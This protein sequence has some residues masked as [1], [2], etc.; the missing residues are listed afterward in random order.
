MKKLLLIAVL[1]LG[2]VACDKNELG[3]DMD[4]SSINVPTEKMIDAKFD[5]AFDFITSLNGSDIMIERKVKSTISTA[6]A[7]DH[8]DNWLQINFFNVGTQDF[9]FL[10][11]DVQGEA[12]AGD[13]VTDISEII[14][15]LTSTELIIETD[16]VSVAYNVPVADYTNTFTTDGPDTVVAVNE[17]RTAAAAAS[18]NVVITL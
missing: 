2:V 9:A 15:T 16:G 8:G 3:M 14:Y 5:A 18:H 4:G 10:R 1:A 6:K 17:G 12:C 13:G 7:G 11:S